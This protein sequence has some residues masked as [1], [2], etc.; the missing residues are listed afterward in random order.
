[1]PGPHAPDV[2][3]RLALESL[4]RAFGYHYAE[5]GLRLRSATP[6]PSIDPAVAAQRSA[7]YKLS[8]GLVTQDLEREL[9]RLTTC[10]QSYRE[11]SK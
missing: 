2:S 7:I 6:E 8:A 5:H 1:M 11:A 10:W 3:R 9:D 4:E